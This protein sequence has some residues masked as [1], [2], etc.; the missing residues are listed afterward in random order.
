MA[1]VVDDI[2]NL[3]E[4]TL[5]DP[6][7]LS[8]VVERLLSSP[9]ETDRITGS[10]HLIK[11]LI[12][13]GKLRDAERLIRLLPIEVGMRAS[14]LADIGA[15]HQ[16]V[17]ETDLSSNLFDEAVQLARSMKDEFWRAATLESIAIC[18]RL[19]GR[20][21]IAVDVLVEA[22]LSASAAE[23]RTRDGDSEEEHVSALNC[24][25]LLISIAQK[26]G[27]LGDWEKA[28]QV[29]NLGR[30]R[31]DEAVRHLDGLRSKL[32]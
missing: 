30:I 15:K 26:L 3:T 4:Q 25:G 20:T 19:V 14:L 24:G 31:R 18:L 9:D 10:Y 29:V 11:R 17:G 21:N 12:Q 22:G 8:D 7:A 6:R 23:A 5:G 16:R 27:E 32:K 1:N 2:L 13:H 28:Y